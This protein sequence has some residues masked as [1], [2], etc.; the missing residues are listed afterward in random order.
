MSPAVRVLSPVTTY[1][2]PVG[3]Y[4]FASG[5]YEGEISDAARNYFEQAGYTIESLAQARKAD[6]AAAKDKA[7]AD[8]A[9]AAQAEADAEA[10]A[11]AEAAQS[12]QTGAGQ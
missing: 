4:V 10:A 6:A 8:E 7:A 11:A 12:Q 1:T 5:K 2:G 9:A 3:E